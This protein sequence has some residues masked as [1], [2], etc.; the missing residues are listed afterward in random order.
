MR[1]GGCVVAVVAAL[2]A[3]AGCDSGDA[4]SPGTGVTG[5]GCT[6]AVATATNAVTIG[7][8]THYLP[9]CIRVT[10]GQEVTWMNLDDTPHTVTSTN[11]PELS[12]PVI[13]TGD[14]F[15]HTFSTPGTV[16]YVSWLDGAVMFGSV[17]VE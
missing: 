14:L 3:V 11:T 2:A 15:R 12:S 13:V 10:R 16:N 7:P 9:M 4:I 6:A 17:V 8:G 5:T 1:D